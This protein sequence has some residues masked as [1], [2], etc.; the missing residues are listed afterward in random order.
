MADVAKSLIAKL[1]AAGLTKDEQLLLAAAIGSSNEPGEV[2]GFV[3]SEDELV[4]FNLGMPP[5]KG[6]G[7]FEIQDLYKSFNQAETLASSFKKHGR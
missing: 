3:A 6:L 5:A 1:E 7:N 2:E 4:A